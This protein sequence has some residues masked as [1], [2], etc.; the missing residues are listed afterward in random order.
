MLAHTQSLQ[1][2]SLICPI[3]LEEKAVAAVRSGLENN[4]SLR[5]LTLRFP[6]GATVV[7][8]ILTSL[9]DHPLLRKLCFRGKLMDL[10][11]L[12]TVL[13]SDTLKI[14]EL[15]IDRSYY[16]RGIP[17]MGLTHVLQAL[18]RRPALT[19]LILRNVSLGRDDARELGVVL[20][21][22]PSL[23][24]LDLKGS[25]LGSVGLA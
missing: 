25:F 17:V 15:E 18:G 6:L 10:T 11:G 12:E 3:G 9:R 5:E 16:Y 24:S 19:K 14:T 23:Q 1:S 21:N 4:T 2:L 7:S 20:C 22:T 13:L 8:P